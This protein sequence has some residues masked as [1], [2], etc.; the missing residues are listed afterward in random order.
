[1]MMPAMSPT[2]TEG[3]ISSWKV[4]EGL[5]TRPPPHYPTNSV[6][7]EAFAAGDVLLEIETDKAQMD[8]EAQDDGVMAKIII[9]GGTK[10]IAVGT[11]IAVLAE[12]GDDL[13]T[14]EIPADKNTE[15]AKESITPQAAKI[16]R[17]A[18]ETP[19]TTEASA[20][21]T[22]ETS[23][24]KV[25]THPSPSVLSL[26]KSNNLDAALIK[27]SGPKGRLLKG[28]VLA[29]LGRISKS[30]PTDLSNRIKTLSKLDLSNIKVA[31]PKPA[32][33][34]AKKPEPKKAAPP[35]APKL[36]ELSLPVSFA[37]ILAASQRRNIPLSQTIN[38][39]ITHANASLPAQKTA[40][41]Q[42]ELFNDL[43]G[44]P[45][46]PRRATVGSYAPT[47]T[48]LPRPG[49][50]IS[51]QPRS[52]DI[53]DELLGVS[54]DI[55]NKRTQPRD[56]IIAGGEN[57]V[58][59]KVQECERERARVFLDRFKAAVERGAEALV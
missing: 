54:A 25:P 52:V 18:N 23:H 5:S 15:K 4:K 29:H 31:A 32:P 17:V 34:P 21:S 39:A 53:F 37:N 56:G 43:L 10:N 57:L 49:A 40:P 46:K 3:A 50:A 6:L 44:L 19:K 59:L 2:M 22:P 27:G 42:D 58:A 35:P 9:P 12:E 28:D 13:A 14:L 16:V 36:A 45:N 47:I 20:E 26:L 41:T 48:P 1:M 30:A 33:A 24:T 8:V 7:G 38:A 51:V 55:I 11:R